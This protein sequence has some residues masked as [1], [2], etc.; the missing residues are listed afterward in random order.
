MRRKSRSELC[1]RR[2]ANP[3]QKYRVGV[4]FLDLLCECFRRVGRDEKARFAV[5]YGF[6]DSRRIAGKIRN[7]HS[8]RLKGLVGNCAR[9]ARIVG[10]LAERKRCLAHERTQTRF[11]EAFD[12]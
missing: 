10:K 7:A 9:E 11:R 4:E 8:E 1:F 3:A 12:D 6:A 2:F 5:S